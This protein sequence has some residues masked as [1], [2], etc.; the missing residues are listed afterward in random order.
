M[1]RLADQN[2]A[3]LRSL[4]PG[5]GVQGSRAEKPADRDAEGNYP[6]DE[7]GDVPPIDDVHEPDRPPRDSP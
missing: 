2:I 6:I 1:Q 3:F 7:L 4:L 5:T